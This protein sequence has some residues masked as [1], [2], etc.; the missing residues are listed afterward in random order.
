MEMQIKT[1]E[2]LLSH[3]LEWLK[4]KG[5]QYQVFFLATTPQG[6]LDLVSARDWTH[7]PTMEA[8]KQKHGV[9][10]ADGQERLTKY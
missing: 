6:M 5:L 8:Q 3:S 4:L 7:T 1:K 9:L 2:M 10:P